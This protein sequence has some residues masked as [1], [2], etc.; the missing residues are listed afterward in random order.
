MA[1]F[2]IENTH[3]GKVKQFHVEDLE[4]VPKDGSVTLLDTR[5]KE[6]FQLGHL[7]NAINIPVDN[8]RES[9]S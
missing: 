5:T 4:T 7:E 6:E 8:I 2:I 3:T 9:L 1:G